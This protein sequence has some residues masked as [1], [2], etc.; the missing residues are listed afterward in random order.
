[1]YLTYSASAESPLHSYSNAL[2]QDPYLLPAQ[3]QNNHIHQYTNHTR[4]PIYP[5]SQACP[6][7]PVLDEL[8][9]MEKL[10]VWVWERW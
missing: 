9:L 3:N 7:K 10:T 5:P 2:T 4:D 6:D 1:M 8:K